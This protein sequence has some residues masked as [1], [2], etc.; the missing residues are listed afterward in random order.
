MREQL[1]LIDDFAAF[2]PG[3][4]R[5]QRLGQ[6]VG[7]LFVGAAFLDV[8]QMC[9]VRL[10]LRR[11]RWIRTVEVRR[12]PAAG[13]IPRF[14]DRRVR[15][16]RGPRFMTVCAVVGD[17]E[18]RRGVAPLGLPIGPAPTRLPRMALPPATFVLPRPS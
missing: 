14:R 11:W 17:V 16:E 9:L 2:A 12:Q 3:A 18:A 15:G 6:D 13:A 10:D 4:E 5:L 1:K 7:R 8:S